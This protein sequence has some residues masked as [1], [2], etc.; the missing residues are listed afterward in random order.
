M[1]RPWAVRRASYPLWAVCLRSP[2]SRDG[3]HRTWTAADPGST[4]PRGGA[5]SLGGMWKAGGRANTPSPAFHALRSSAGRAGPDQASPAFAAVPPPRR[6]DVE[7]TAGEPG[8]GTDPLCRAEQEKTPGQGP[9]RPS[10]CRG[11]CFGATILRPATSAVS[12][13]LRLGSRVP[14]LERQ[15]RTS[16]R[17]N[18]H[19]IAPR[20]STRAGQS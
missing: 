16:V 4:E 18:V 2:R 9:G 15:L 13:S 5:A 6:E 10:A 14:V 1:K 3:R 11:A 17:Q 20:S 8:A 7:H 19:A 12:M